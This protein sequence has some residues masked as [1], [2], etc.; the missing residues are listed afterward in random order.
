MIWSVSA[1][2][3]QDQGTITGVV[4]DSQGHLVPG[5]DVTLQDEGT[6]LTLRTKTDNSGVYVFS[7]IKIGRY[8]LT[9]SAPS[10]S[11]TVQNGVDLQ[12]AQRLGITL[13]LK[14][15]SSTQTVTVTNAAPILQTED[16]SVGNVVT[17]KELE[18]SP[19]LDRNYV[20]MA[21]LVPGITQAV[22]DRGQDDFSANG[23]RSEENSFI[24]DGVDNNVHLPDYLSEAS[25]VITPPEEALSEFKVQ[26]SNYSAEFGTA[27]GAVVNATLKSGTNHFHGGAWEFLRNDALDARNYFATT[28]PELRQNEFGAML[29]GPILRDKLFFFGDY[30]GE[31]I[32][33][34][35][36]GI[37]TVP[38]ANMRSGNFT[39]LLSST[40]TGGNPRILYVP[41]TAGTVLQQCNGQQNVLCSSQI[42]PVAQN[43]LNAFPAPNYGPVGQTYNNYNVTQKGTNDINQFD[44][45][46]DWNP[47]HK[48]QAFLRFSFADGNSYNPPPFGTPLSGGSYTNG[49]HPTTSRNFVFSETHIFNSTLVNEL[50]FGYNYI[51][52]AFL[53]AGYNDPSIASSFGLGGI[54][55]TISENGGLPIFS[56]SGLTAFGTSSYTPIHET[57]NV[58]EILDNITKV[59]GNHTFKAGFS[60]SSVRTFSLEPSD[61]RGLFTYDG[62]YTE[63]PA[64]SSSTG[65]GVADFLADYQDTS[66]IS[67]TAIVGES[68]W[69]RSA[70]A[71]DDWI[72]NQKLTV[73]LGLRYDYFQP[74]TEQNGYLAN[75][76]PNSTYT[77]ATYYIPKTAANVPITSTYHQ[78]FAEDNVQVAY[79]G[80]PSLVNAPKNNIAPRIGFAYTAMPRLVFRGAYGIFYGGSED[81][82]FGN[83]NLATNPPFSY[84]VNLSSAG[85]TLG[86]CPTNGITLA[87]GFSSL[88]AAGFG[89]YPAQPNLA[90]TVLN[91]KTTAV[92]QWNAAVQYQLTDT[93]ALNLMYVGSVTRHLAAYV[94]DNQSAVLI[95]PG[96][97]AQAARP[98]PNFTSGNILLDDAAAN[99]NS[100]QAQL[101]KRLSK[102]LGFS[103]AYTYAHALGNDVDVFNPG[104]NYRNPRQLGINYDYGSSLLD[105]RHR[106]TLNL[107]YALP[108]GRGNQFLSRASWIE[109]AI[110]GGWATDL[111]FRVQTGQPVDI[112]PN[113]N[114][115]NGVGAAYAYKAGNPFSTNLSSPSVGVTCATHVKTPLTWFNPCAFQNP[116]PATGPN[117]IEAY[118]PPGRTQVSSPGYN[119][120]DL[121]LFKRFSIEKQS[122]EFRADVFNLFNSPYFGTPSATIG[123]GFGQITATQN[124]YGSAS[125]VIQL[126][127]EYSF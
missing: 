88:L 112:G 37:F 19:V 4:N 119:E 107:Q 42:S 40:L 54:P 27:A 105:V 111:L 94:F 33:N 93:L 12:I 3:Q 6:G 113:N 64:E 51:N 62:K 118:G 102:G 7:P 32:I 17:P 123:S 34:A 101:T 63:N 69:F 86:S 66:A 10:F 52:T 35:T 89:N 41:G 117:D 126:A 74:Y 13:T 60:I 25:F 67:N 97:N 103:S 53:Q 104:L 2:A 30:Q 11:K 98:F 110:L 57:E 96:S 9:A 106:A 8:T 36:T 50:R 24:L 115:T 95:T 55:S 29:G 108:V 45:R 121:S 78:M 65:F 28:T 127:L 56:V 18:D 83:M 43:L 91:P 70:Y 85:C 44:V 79:T 80:N 59:V 90:G 81:L 73:N 100:F 46:V 21:Q 124:A 92:Q 47:T 26:T 82:G 125:R 72:V 99:Y 87:N 68:R 38:T 58:Y 84:N 116:T 122:L 114:P 31:R 1:R 77:G 75:F 49:L 16:A 71:Q 39:E 14:P 23:M 15:G 76:I 48:D 5:A 109:D 20:F 22:G 120:I 61:S